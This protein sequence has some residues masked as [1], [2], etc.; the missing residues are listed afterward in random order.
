MT[1][2]LLERVNVLSS[3]SSDNDHVNK[4]PDVAMKASLQD[5]IIYNNFYLYIIDGN[6]CTRIIDKSMIDDDDDI[7][8]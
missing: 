5:E 6:K 7:Y 3:E 2:N 8:Q 4:K 1:S